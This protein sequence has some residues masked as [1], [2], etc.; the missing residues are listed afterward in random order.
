M[1]KNII[2]SALLGL[3]A[4]TILGVIGT[5]TKATSLRKNV[6]KNTDEYLSKL[7]VQLK[8]LLKLTKETATQVSSENKKILMKD[9]QNPT[10]DEKL[11]VK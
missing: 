3:T 2:I 8:E 9:Y 5:S 1:K 4:G 11:K 7:K 6:I 10:T